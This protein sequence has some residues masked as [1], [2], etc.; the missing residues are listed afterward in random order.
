[1]RQIVSETAVMGSMIPALG[2]PQK[3][4][5]REA[6]IVM[7]LIV[8]IVCRVVAPLSKSVSFDESASPKY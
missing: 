6:V 7:R 5:L 4:P 3:F 1:M 2:V 8:I